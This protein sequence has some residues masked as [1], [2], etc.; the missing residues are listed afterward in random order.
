MVNIERQDFSHW[1]ST[2][3]GLQI[4]DEPTWQSLPKQVLSLNGGPYDLDRIK[5]VENIIDIIGKDTGRIA[6]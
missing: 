5:V 2:L 3:R 4:F 6:I 1:F